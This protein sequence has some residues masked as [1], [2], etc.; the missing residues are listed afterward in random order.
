M[1]EVN[2]NSN[3]RQARENLRRAREAIPTALSNVI[4]NLAKR[5]L[6]DSVREIDELVYS[7]PES[8]S[9]PRTKNLRRA[10]KI[11]PV[12]PFSWM[13]YNDAEYAGH[14]HDGT[15]QMEPRPWMRNA[16][17]AL[18]SPLTNAQVARETAQAVQRH[19]VG[20]RRR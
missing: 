10:N 15:S 14:V 4:G 13:L 19:F 2:I 16:V 6:R 11:R 1:P 18:R 7:T 12:G 9:Y 3:A 5:G 20:G 17:D 8:P